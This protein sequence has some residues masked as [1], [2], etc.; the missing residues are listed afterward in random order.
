MSTDA[1]RV[2]HWLKDLSE[3]FERQTL[4]PAYIARKIPYISIEMLRDILSRCIL[5]AHRDLYDVVPAFEN[6][7]S[8]YLQSGV[9]PSRILKL[10]GVSFSPFSAPFTFIVFKRSVP[11]KSV[12]ISMTVQQVERY[13]QEERLESVL[14]NHIA[15]VL[16]EIEHASKFTP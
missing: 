1:D 12:V 2:Y 10:E 11:T 4:Q 8:E 7:Y 5:D 16:K 9:F 14:K 15:V 3:P 6:V 13:F